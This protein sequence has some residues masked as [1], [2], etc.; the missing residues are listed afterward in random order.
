[1]TGA[2]QLQLLAPVIATQAQ[3]IDKI[4]RLALW[5]WARPI[6]EARHN[7]N[8]AMPIRRDRE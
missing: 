6:V 1:V 5:L 7:K 8:M 3:T 2:V 4:G